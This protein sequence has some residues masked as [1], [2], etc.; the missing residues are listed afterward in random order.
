MV[1]TR[2]KKK[3]E[4]SRT[5]PTSPAQNLVTDIPESMRDAI[6]TMRR[7]T[8]VR[9]VHEHAEPVVYYEQIF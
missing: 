9:R 1:A 8:R 7:T 4:H 3:R 5:S 2:P 6:E